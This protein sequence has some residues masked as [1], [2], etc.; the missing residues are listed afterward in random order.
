M[1][2]LS[3]KFSDETQDT[4]CP[5]IAKRHMDCYSTKLNS[6]T[7]AA[8]IFYCGGSFTQCTV[9]KKLSTEKLESL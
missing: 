7:I 2:G 4:T 6:Q 5:F 1:V 9:Y 8:T 3:E